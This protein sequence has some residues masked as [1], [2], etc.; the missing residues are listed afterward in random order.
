[1]LPSES[2]IEEFVKE[3]YKIHPSLSAVRFW[4]VLV[5]ALIA[6]YD[7]HLEGDVRPAEKLYDD[8]MDKLREE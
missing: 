5:T 6:H 8:V 4:R 1:L 7:D 2:K 3:L